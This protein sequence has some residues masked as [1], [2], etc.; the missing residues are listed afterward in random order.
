[1]SL[2][3]SPLPYKTHRVSVP[4]LTVL[5]ALTARIA[6]AQATPS[7]VAPDAPALAAPRAPAAPAPPPAAATAV[8]PA[9]FAALSA[10]VEEAD[11]NAR[12]A[13]RKLELLE[14]QLAAKAKESPG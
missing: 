10:K 5:I 4:V 3:F 6:W 9:A 2:F 14:E 1:M 11:Q 12:I 7:T 8:D 13:G